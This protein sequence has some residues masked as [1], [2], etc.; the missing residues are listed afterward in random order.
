MTQPPTAQ[1]SVTMSAIR[2]AK[3]VIYYLIRRGWYDQ[4]LRLCDGIIKKGKD[5]V[6]MF[7]KAFAHGMSGDI[8]GSIAQLES[9]SSGRKDM[10]YPISLALKYFRSRM[11]NPDQD[12]IDLLAQWSRI[13]Q[14]IAGDD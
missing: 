14:A 6:T 9:F 1:N 5:P 2:E 7:W 3:P 12:A 11:A 4:L 10:Q 13:G 8:V